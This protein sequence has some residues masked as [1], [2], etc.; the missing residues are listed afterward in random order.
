MPAGA[1]EG[2][3]DLSLPPE[4]RNRLQR[5]EVAGVRSAGAVSLTDDSLKRRKVAIIDGQAGREGL[6]L[7]SPTHYLERALAPVADLLEGSLQEVLLASP[8][9]VILADVARLAP[10]EQDAVLDWLEEQETSTPRRK[11]AGGRR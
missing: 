10:E 6:L 7:L 11:R 4:L 3:V 1:T 5:F 8:D 2:E 9:V